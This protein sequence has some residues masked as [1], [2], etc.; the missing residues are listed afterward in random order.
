[1]TD[2]EKAVKNIERLADI[3]HKLV[4]IR[5]RQESNSRDYN[6]LTEVIDEVIELMKVL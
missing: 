1:M 6:A 2:L 3:G 4:S 5:S